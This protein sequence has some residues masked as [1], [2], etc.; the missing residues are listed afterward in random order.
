MCPAYLV[1]FIEEILNGKLH[2]FAVHGNIYNTRPVKNQNNIQTVLF[3]EMVLEMLLVFLHQNQQ[4]NSL[5]VGPKFLD[6]CRISV[7]L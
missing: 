2:F 1:A 5:V 4:K 6:T 7:F 3:T